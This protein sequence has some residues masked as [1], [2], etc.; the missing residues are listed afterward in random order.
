M[1]MTTRDGE[2]LLESRAIQDRENII[3]V[4]MSIE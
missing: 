2:R 4:E 3:I 1:P